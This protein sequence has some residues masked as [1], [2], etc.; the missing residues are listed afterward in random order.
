VPTRVTFWTGIWRPGEEALSNEIHAVRSAIAHGSPV[1]SFSQGQRSG[2]SLR[3]RVIKLSAG[4]WATLR[5]VA[6]AIEPMGDVSHVWSSIGDWHLLRSVGRRPTL[7]TVAYGG[8]AWPV[9]HY[10]F[11]KRF[12]VEADVLA[13]ALVQA[14][15]EAARIE[16]VIPGVDLVS[17]VPQPA[18]TGRFKLLFASAPASPREF[19][20]RGVT[21]L[22]EVARAIPGIDVSLLWRSWG[23]QGAARRA[24]LALSPPRNLTVEERGDRTMPEVYGS[25][26]AVA[27][28]YA[29]GFGKTVPNSVVEALAC[30]RPVIVSP[31]CGV[32]GLVERA[33]AGRVASRL[34]DVVTAVAE[35]EDDWVS[36]SRR[37]RKLAEL[38]FD[39][40][41]FVADY[42]RL[43]ADVAER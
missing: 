10:R 36:S 32:A 2:M 4:R 17:F 29:E 12:A 15:V 20:A 21:T 22:V 6:G 25:A 43:Y 19:E 18:P 31:S 30:G 33:G 9:A 23:D 11:V 42:S 7:F 35:I 27:C 3:D 39:A 37:A 14:G 26:H 5:L 40:S 34:R 28:L 1:I 16:V 24:L 13:D 41:R 38:S 8:T